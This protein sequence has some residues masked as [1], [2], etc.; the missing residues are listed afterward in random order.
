MVRIGHPARFDHRT[1]HVISTKDSH[2]GTDLVG[3]NSSVGVHHRSGLP[4]RD[5]RVGPV[6][7]HYDLHAGNVVFRYH[8]PRR[9]NAEREYNRKNGNHRALVAEQWGEEVACRPGGQHLV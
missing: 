4:R 3:R 2:F 6:L 5:R 9:V 8:R 1:Q 7:L